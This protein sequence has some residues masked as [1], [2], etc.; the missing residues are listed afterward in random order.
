[1]KISVRNI[2]KRYG[3]QWI[4]KNFDFTF[5][6]NTTYAIKGYNGSGKST[7]LK[8]I[9]GI[10]SVNKGRIE[11]FNQNTPLDIETIALQTQLVAPYQELIEEL[12]LQEFLTFHFNLR[13]SP[14]SIENFKQLVDLPTKKQIRYFSSGMK[15]R[16]KLGIAFFSNC[17]LLLLDEPT[18][19]LDSEGI[20]WYQ[21]LLKNH[22][23]DR[24][25]IIASNQAF[26]YENFCSEI[27][28]IASYSR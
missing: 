1:M 11:Y 14:T 21:S 10:E 4:F 16:V 8:V 12:T 5:S 23:K 22:S 24:L 28:D 26:E 3:N 27:I 6:E 18:S 9:S 25:I 7:L 19:N 2:S 17:K 13:N 15:Q 20:A